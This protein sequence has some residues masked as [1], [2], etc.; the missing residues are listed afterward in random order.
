LTHN[1][2]PYPAKFIPQIPRNLI[3]ALSKE[4]DTILDPFCGGGTT[5]VEAI[6]LDRNAIGVDTNPVGVISS[7]VK[8]TKLNEDELTSIDTHLKELSE[9]LTKKE[10]VNLK[11]V[12]PDI[13]NIDLWFRDSVVKELSYIKS[14]IEQIPKVKAKEFCEVALSS[15]IVKVS[16]QK[17]ETIYSSIDKDI[18]EYDVIKQYLSKLKDMR[19]RITE[20]NTAAGTGWL[21]VYV[22]D[23]RS[24]KK[25]NELADLAITSPPYPNA[26]DYHLYH[27]HRISWLG[28]NPLDVKKAEIGS[29]LNYQGKKVDEIS[30]FNSDFLQHLKS[31]NKKIKLGGYYCIVIGDSKFHGNIIHNAGI[32]IELAQQSG[33]EC[34]ANIVRPLPVTKRSFNINA[35]RANQ[36]N[37]LILRK[38]HE[39]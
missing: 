29:H 38:N 16:K 15:I 26:F 13:K 10:I 28:H 20:F 31:I 32:I 23:A 35:R 33:F 24:L 39:I 12:A 2:H 3:L 21:K 36:E 25:V 8:S 22:D 6:L 18:K 1:F 4:G 9:K 11:R 5:L 37:I 19:K 14:L 34:S 7:R 30:I 27:K 17:G